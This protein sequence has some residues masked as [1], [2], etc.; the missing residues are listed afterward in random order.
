[1]FSASPFILPARPTNFGRNLFEF[2]RTHTVT[3]RSTQ[4]YLC[5]TTYVV[6]LDFL[7]PKYCVNCKKLGSYLCSD[8]F[9]Y[10]SF[11]TQGMCLVCGHPSIDGLTH[12]RCRSSY[13]IDGAFSSIPYK[14]VA[15]KLLYV[16]KYKPYVTAIQNLLGDLFY[17]GIIQNESFI[18]T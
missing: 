9:S 3:L 2:F 10:L 16:F 11:D 5:Y 4:V 7:F 13:A 8:C 12:P 6:V 15:K 17:E 18:S 14:G 1:M